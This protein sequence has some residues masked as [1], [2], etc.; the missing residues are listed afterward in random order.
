MIQTLGI[1]SQDITRRLVAG[2][3][4]FNVAE[5]AVVGDKIDAHDII[6]VLGLHLLE[7]VALALPRQRTL[8]VE[9]DAV[10]SA[11]EGH[12]RQV[13]GIVVTSHRLAQRRATV[14]KHMNL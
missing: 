3:D 5:T 10:G 1:G 6:W 4:G 8:G 2:L 12:L 13:I 9:Q 7:A 14:A 11:H